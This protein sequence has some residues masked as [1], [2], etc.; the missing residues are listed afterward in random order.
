VS[1]SVNIENL[2][3]RW[4]DY[5][6][7]WKKIFFVPPVRESGQNKAMFKWINRG[8]IAGIVIQKT[9]LNLSLIRGE[10]EQILPLNKGELEGVYSSFLQNC[11]KEEKILP[12][13]LAKVLKYNLEDIW[14]KGN[15]KN[16]EIQY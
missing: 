8:S 10:I 12:L 4:S 7:N 11:I 6:A 1:V 13:T 16:L 5:K 14:F 15:I 9:P 2:M 3:W